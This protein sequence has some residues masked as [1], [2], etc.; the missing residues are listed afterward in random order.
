ML[1]TADANLSWFP[2]FTKKPGRTKRKQ[3]T[4]L[5]GAPRSQTNK[6]GFKVPVPSS[7]RAL[8][9]GISET[10]YNCLRSNTLNTLHFAYPQFN[11]KAFLSN[12]YDKDMNL[13]GLMMKIQKEGFVTVLFHDLTLDQVKQLI[14]CFPH[15]MLLEVPVSKQMSH[16]I[17]IVTKDNAVHVI[18]GNHPQGKPFLFTEE[19][20][21]WI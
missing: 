16:L 10:K 3:G 13:K 12:G 21:G 4:T 2:R 7:D 15:N 18:D 8:E 14:Q 17:G 5:T 11:E 20:F 9:R 6:R 1:P 19:Y